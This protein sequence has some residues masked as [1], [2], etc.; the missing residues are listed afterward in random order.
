MKLTI[1]QLKEKLTTL[2]KHPRN[3]GYYG[4]LSRSKKSDALLEDVALELNMTESQV[5]FVLNSSLARHTMDKIEPRNFNQ[6]H[7]V[8]LL[9]LG[10]NKIEKVEASYNEKL[11]RPYRDNYFN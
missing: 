6:N 1:K 10:L 8:Q 7:A 2:D 5:D 4:H 3:F 9:G 11:G